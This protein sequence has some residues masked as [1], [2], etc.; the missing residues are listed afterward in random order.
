MP[1]REYNGNWPC[2]E[3]GCRERARYVY[4]TR[5]DFDE[6]ARRYAKDPYLCVRHS[7][8]GEVLGVGNLVVRAETVASRV[9]Y[10]GYERR[11]ADY[12]QAVARGSEFA[13]KPDEF[14]PGLFW[15][16]AGLKS[17][18]THGPGFKAFADDFPEGTKLV[19]TAEIVLPEVPS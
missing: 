14:L 15:T 18:F 10:G 9:P 8:T 4:D 13:R 3:N 6:A 1:R 19:I 2:A 11:L 12:E 5:R 16:G 7:K 17:G